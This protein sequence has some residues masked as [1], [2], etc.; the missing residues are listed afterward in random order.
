MAPL[1][2][3][4]PRGERLVGYAPFGHWN[5]MTFV[6]ALRADRVSAPFILDG[7]ING[8][9]FRIYVQQV[10]VPEL[11]A[12]DIV[13]LDNLGSH[14]GQEIRAAIRKAGARLFFLPKYS[15]DL[16]PIEKLFA[17]IKHWLREAQARSRDAIHDELRH[18][19]QAVTPQ[20]C[21][22]YF[23][24]AGYERAEIH[25][26]LGRLPLGFTDW[27]NH[28]SIRSSSSTSASVLPSK[29][30]II[31]DRKASGSTASDRNGCLARCPSM[32]MNK[33]WVLPFPSRKG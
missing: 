27:S 26:A 16:N 3:W 20:E 2:G 14:K 4:A 13:I 9:R 10:L 1:R 17:K 25:T 7:P 19:L 24:E 11:K 8:E 31:A 33:S 5:T 18:I 28:A 21:A 22:A 23:K 6:A 15:P 29:L 30:W 32:R 12:G